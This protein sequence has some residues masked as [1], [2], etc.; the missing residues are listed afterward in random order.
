MESASCS[1]TACVTLTTEGPIQYSVTS[2]LS[3]FTTAVMDSAHLSTPGG[4]KLIG[5]S[6]PA[7][8]NGNMGTVPSGAYADAPLWRADASNILE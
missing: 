4:P 5:P 2:P 3:V 7:I 8:A 6:R 1:V